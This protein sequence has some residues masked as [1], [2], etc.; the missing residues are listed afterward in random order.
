[1]TLDQ[2]KK[3]GESL[4]KGTPNRKQIALTILG[5]KVRELI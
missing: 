3:F 5:D 1:V 4:A 2:A